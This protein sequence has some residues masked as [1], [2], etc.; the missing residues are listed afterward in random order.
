MNK[1]IKLISLISAPILLGGGFAALPLVS[2]CGNQKQTNKLNK[3]FK[4]TEL[5]AV[6]DNLDETILP[7]LFEKNKIG[8]SLQ[9]KILDH[10]QIVNDT[11]D[12]ATCTLAPNIGD[13]TFT[14]ELIIGYGVA[15][16]DISGLA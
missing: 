16:M 4:E 11:R 3:I 2:Q 10:C 13:N 15:R 9:K 5:G 7:K 6:E 12:F 1:K 8:A 14:G